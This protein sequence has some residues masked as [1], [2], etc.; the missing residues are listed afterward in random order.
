MGAA[1][2]QVG[3]SDTAFAHRDA[4]YDFV[5]GCSWVD[6]EHS[7]E[8]VA[9]MRNLW[10]QIVPFTKGFYVNNAMEESID[11]VRQ[12]YRGNYDRLVVL[13]NKHD[14]TNMFHRNANIQPSV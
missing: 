1:I 13:K 2:A 3:E 12:T 10:K 14:P 11:R 8:N 9:Y 4:E 5:T 7:D 6:R